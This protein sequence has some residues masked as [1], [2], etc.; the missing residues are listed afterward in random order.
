MA[1]LKS[2]TMILQLICQDGVVLLSQASLL[3]DFQITFSCSTND[4]IGLHFLDNDLLHF[5]LDF[6]K[7]HDAPL[8]EKFFLKME[9]T[10]IIQYCKLSK[11]LVK[12]EMTTTYFETG[13]IR[14]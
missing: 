1:T 6:S 4:T 10:G 11:K 8:N 13:R 5:Y 12:E 7:E 9:K 2:K 3:W 14:L